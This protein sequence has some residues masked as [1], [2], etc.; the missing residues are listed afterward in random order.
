V[1]GIFGGGA[2]R[3]L[4]C[5]DSGNTS[6]A[7]E[8]ARDDGDYR[9][10]WWSD[11]LAKVLGVKAYQNVTVNERYFDDPIPIYLNEGTLLDV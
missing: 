8:A 10:R 4:R 11:P 1:V 3:A 2:E 9:A 5:T 7:S 6:Q